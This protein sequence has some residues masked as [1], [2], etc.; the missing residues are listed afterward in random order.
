MNFDILVI[1]SGPAG[2]H[3]ASVA[4]QAGATVGMVDDNPLPGGQIWRQGPRH[5]PQGRGREAIDAV[6]NAANVT[7]LHGTRVVQALRSHELL[8]EDAARG[9]TV[10]YRKIIIT[11]GARE[12]FLPYPGWTLPGVTGAGGLQ[13]LV[14]GGMPVRGQRIVIA[15]TGPLLWAAAATA[16]E[17]GAQVVA[18]VEQAPVHSVRRFALSLVHT[19]AKLAQAARMRFDLRATPYLC[20]AHV[21]A[22]HGEG[23]LTQVTVQQGYKQMRQMR[24]TRIDCDRLACAYGL[25]PNTMLGTALGCDVDETDGALA[26][27]V[28]ELQATSQPDIYAAGECTGVGGMELSAVEGRIAALAAVGNVAQARALFAQRERY[29]RFAA[30]MHAAFAL[31][32]RLRALAA[33]DTVICRCEDVRFADAA[34][35]RSWRDAKLHTRCGMGPCQGKICGEAAAFCLGWSRDGLRPPFS[36]ARI[37]TLMEAQPPV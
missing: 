34:Q 23:K 30:R 29:R 27:V 8:V 33:P 31:D 15:G 26:I 12:R 14:K 36:P 9:Y 4:A 21:S 13:A 11:T 1:G 18:I 28:D 3:A 24:Q 22:A 32:P 7:R 37:G 19:P 17:Q 16:R 25:V 35:H 20:G 10:G 2:L 5:R 6:A